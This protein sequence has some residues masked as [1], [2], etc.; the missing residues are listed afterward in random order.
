MNKKLSIK[1]FFF[2]CA[3]VP[4]RDESVQFKIM[5]GF[6]VV[7]VVFCCLPFFLTTSNKKWVFYLSTFIHQFNT[8]HIELLRKHRKNQICIFKCLASGN[9]SN[10][11]PLG[12]WCFEPP[13]GTLLIEAVEVPYPGSLTIFPL[14]GFVL[15]FYKVSA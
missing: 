10:S 5:E 15:F 3:L 2:L 9:K 6:L 14:N 11:D 8:E 13:L 4:F 7:F 12:Q 1:M